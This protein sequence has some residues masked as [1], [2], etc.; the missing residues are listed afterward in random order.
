MSNEKR[1]SWGSRSQ[2]IL[3]SIGSAVGLGNAWRFPGLAAKHGGGAFLLVYLIAMLA[4]GIP[5]L[6]MEISIGRKMHRGVPGALRA[7]N[8]PTEPIGWF[9]VSNAFVISVY[10]AVVFAWVIMMAFASYKFAGLTGDSETASGIW[11]AMIKTTGTTSGYGTI[12]LPVLGC[13]VIAWVLI[14]TCIR[15]GP[16]TVG[17]VVKYTV[18]LPIICLLILAIKGM[19]MSGAMEGLTKFFVPD[20]SSLSSAD[21]WID[22]IGQVFYSLSIMMAIMVA[23]GS[24]L[25]EDSN[26]AKDSVIIA[27]S[28]FAISVLSGIVLFTTMSG[29]GQLENMTA[30]GIGTAF[31]VYPQSIVLLTNNGVANAIFAFVFYFCLCTLAIDSAFS[32]IEGVSTA[33]SDK[34]HLS[35]KKTTLVLCIVASILSIWFVTGAGLAWLDIVDNWCNAFS[36]IMVGILEAITIGWLFNPKKVLKEVNHNTEGFKMPSWWF[37]TSIKFFAPLALTGF[38]VWNIYALFKAGGIYGADSGYSLASNIIGGWLILAICFFSG[39]IVKII[40]KIMAKKGY[41]PDE[42]V[43]EDTEE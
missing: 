29:T 14:Y 23:Y 6:M 15:N 24:F 11:A 34:F 9:A 10:Y 19:L 5:F 39:F 43:W 30:S 33:I 17:K 22:A 16:G 26:I 32:I 3:A 27:F 35:H 21:I 38:F 25:T 7:I 1:D 13:L 36:L 42:D 31:I 4:I 41:T 20:F 18:F 28:D 40:E 8:K 2:F 12:S 37:V